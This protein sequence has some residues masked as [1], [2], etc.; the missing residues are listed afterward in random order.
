MICCLV[1][2]SCLYL[3]WSSTSVPCKAGSE[4]SLFHWVIDVQC[5]FSNNLPSSLIGHCICFSFLTQPCPSSVLELTMQSINVSCYLPAAHWQ[6]V[7]RSEVPVILWLSS[8]LLH[9]T[10]NCGLCTIT[11]VSRPSIHDAGGCGALHSM[12]LDHQTLQWPAWGL[13]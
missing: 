1:L 12:R 3:T 11:I 5:A 8:C 9:Y 10:K 4:K 2:V 13:S 6:P 7:L